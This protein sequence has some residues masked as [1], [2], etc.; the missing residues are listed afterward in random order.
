MCC[1]DKCCRTGTREGP[2]D[3]VRR[4]HIFPELA[5]RLVAVEAE[6]GPARF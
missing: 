5:A 2:L 4:D 6:V 1:C 3:V